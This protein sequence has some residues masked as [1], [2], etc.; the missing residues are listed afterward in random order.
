MFT[1]EAVFVTL[2]FLP[3]IR[4][5]SV[6]VFRFSLR[7]RVFRARSYL[8]TAMR[9][10]PII[11]RAWLYV[12]RV[13]YDRCVHISY[14]AFLLDSIKSAQKFFFFSIFVDEPC[15]SQS[16]SRANDVAV[17]VNMEAEQRIRKR[18]VRT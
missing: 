6:F 11:A 12:R 2:D 3:R 13:V 1:G 16:R 18:E 9:R 5:E 4:R 17:L 8:T 14:F 7:G 10:F 15:A